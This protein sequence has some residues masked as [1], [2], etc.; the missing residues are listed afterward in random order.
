MSIEG[1]Q[2]RQPQKIEITDAKIEDLLEIETLL[3]ETWMATYVNEER[4]ITHAE[5]ENRVNRIYGPETRDLRAMRIRDMQPGERFLVA[6]REG[7][8]VGV[9]RGARAGTIV[10]SGLFSL[11]MNELQALYVSPDQ[12]K[13]G[14][15]RE[16]WN[17]VRAHFDPTKD[18]I[19]TVADYNENAKDFYKSLGFVEAELKPMNRRFQFESGAYIPER[20]MILPA[21]S[22]T[23]ETQ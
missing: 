18:T 16:L 5:V 9:T 23:I 14:V 2:E 4:G 20:V 6:R 7:K 10:P 17:Q 8:I 19:L 22:A 1:K 12:Q 21:T 15:G 3:K 11:S 13:T